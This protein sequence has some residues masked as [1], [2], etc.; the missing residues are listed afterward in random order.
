MTETPKD[1]KRG[2]SIEALRQRVSAVEGRFSRIDHENIDYRQRLGDLM[3]T[4][5]EDQKQRHDEIELLEKRIESVAS[6]NDQLREILDGLLTSAETFGEGQLDEPLADL[7]ARVRGQAG[8]MDLIGEAAARIGEARHAAGDQDDAV[9][10]KDEAG[11]EGDAKVADDEAE[12]SEKPLNKV[13]AE[14]EAV[15]GEIVVEEPD[16]APGPDA[17]E[18]AAN[19]ASGEDVLELEAQVVDV[20]VETISPTEAKGDTPSAPTP[21]PSSKPQDD[22]GSEKKTEAAAAGD[23]KKVAVDKAKAAEITTDKETDQ[24]DRILA[25]IRRITSAL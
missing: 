23:K 4:V 5:E 19:E 24:L 2:T 18:L 7:D 17:V 6:E 25:S 8:S 3:A 16:L 21:T 20:E 11:T 22:A 10:A 1:S 13:E 12:P 15:D 14:A 9:E